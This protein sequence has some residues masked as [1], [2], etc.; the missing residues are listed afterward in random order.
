MAL[1]IV[2]QMRDLAALEENRSYIVKDQGCLPILV[3]HL[4][5]ENEEVQY[6]ALEAIYYLSMCQTNRETVCSPFSFSF[7][8]MLCCVVL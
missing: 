2:K 7:S 3:S 8:F 1:E 4:T 6:V 5:N